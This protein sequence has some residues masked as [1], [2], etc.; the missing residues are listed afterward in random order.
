MQIHRQ[1]VLQRPTHVAGTLR[2]S[3]MNA[4]VMEAVRAGCWTLVQ[5]RN[6]SSS[7]NI[8]CGVGVTGNSNGGSMSW[9]DSIAAPGPAQGFSSVW[10][11]STGGLSQD[12]II[13]LFLWGLLVVWT[14]CQGW[15][16]DGV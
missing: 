6:C 13:E 7:N 3:N 4:A 16:M 9:Q 14:V 11:L 15:G 5:H 8:S 10:V 2:S 1:Q 12:C